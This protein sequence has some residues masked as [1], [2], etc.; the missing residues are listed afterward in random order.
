M[1]QSDSLQLSF[2]FDEANSNSSTDCNAEIELACKD[3]M[4][5]P[6][7]VGDAD[8]FSQTSLALSQI[9]Q[10]M[11]NS[12][13]DM[14]AW[15]FHAVFIEGLSS[16]EASERIQ[17]MPFARSAERIR[18]IAQE[19][20]EQLLAGRRIKSLRHARLRD[21]LTT[22]LRGMRTDCVVDQDCYEPLTNA[23]PGVAFLLGYR[24]LSEDT[25]LPLL[26]HPIVLGES[27]S[28]GN[29]LSHFTAILFCLQEEVRPLSLSD[30]VVRM[31]QHTSMCGVPIDRKTIK[32][33]LGLR[34]YI[35]LTREADGGAWYSLRFEFLKIYQKAARIIYE[36]KSLSYQQIKDEMELRDGK[37]ESPSMMTVRSH[38]PWCVPMGKTLWLYRPQEDSLR[39]IREVVKEYCKN[40]VRFTFDELQGTLKEMGYDM[41][42]KSLR[43]YILCHCRAMNADSKRFCLT[44]AV[45]EDEENLYRKKAVYLTR[46]RHRTYHDV[47]RN[48][49]EQMLLQAPQHILPLATLKTECAKFLKEKN[50]HEN[51]FY[52]IVTSTKQFKKIKQQ[53]T[54]LLQ[55]RQE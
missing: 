52:K 1:A 22:Q 30:L 26:T 28:S 6:T 37:R 23:L 17:A 7:D 36:R 44:S 43:N 25:R 14:V 18:Q 54:I 12:T 27:I 3:Y 45:T 42:E 33:V 38:H 31:S 19:L 32:A 2:D 5:F 15:V 49:I 55:L 13:N 50:V 16:K 41:K 9:D 51:M 35:T 24:I 48:K 4:T 53:N 8:V 29:F 34:K 47:L 10:R 46:N 11:G 39:N 21:S 40:K 20:R